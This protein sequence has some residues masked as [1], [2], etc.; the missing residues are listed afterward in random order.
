MTPI[1]RSFSSVKRLIASGDFSSERMAKKPSWPRTR[2]DA[3]DL[4]VEP[5]E[6]PVAF[7]AVTGEQAA[8][9]LG[10]IDE[11]RPALEDRQRAAGAFGVD[12]GGN[13]VVGRDLEKGRVV[14]LAPCRY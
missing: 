6:R 8:G 3:A 2:P 14:L 1:S 13:L 5:L 7:G 4:P 10:E 11:D 12:N 9:L